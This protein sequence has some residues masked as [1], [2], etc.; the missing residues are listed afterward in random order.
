MTAMEIWQI[1]T[2]SDVVLIIAAIVIIWLV[3]IITRLNQ[4][5]RDA[6]S[7]NLEYPADFVEPSVADD[8]MRERFMGRHYK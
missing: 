2:N 5:L 8:D 4:K 6:N 1:V 7:Y 3:I